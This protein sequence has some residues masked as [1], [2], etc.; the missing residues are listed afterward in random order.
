MMYKVRERRE[1]ERK[2][3]KRNKEKKSG[4]V[5]V[6][7]MD[8]AVSLADFSPTTKPLRS[9]VQ[10]KYNPYIIWREKISTVS[11]KKRLC[12]SPFLR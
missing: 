4:Q 9:T 5:S 8:R 7:E 3:K 2:K 10:C 1:I 12:R 11:E 6:I